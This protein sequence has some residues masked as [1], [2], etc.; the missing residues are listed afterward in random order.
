MAL[1]NTLSARGWALVA[2]IVFSLVVWV[3]VAVVAGHYKSKVE[4]AEDAGVQSSVDATGSSV[5]AEQEQAQAPIVADYHAEN[6][7]AARNLEVIKNE[8]RSL[9]SKST[10]SLDADLTRVVLVGLCRDP[11]RR[12]SPD[13][14]A[15][16]D[17]PE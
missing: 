14:A 13:C 9:D 17:N 6:A 16:I 7:Q 15:Y 12:D 11:A 3:T 2:L 4:K 8:I 5:Q 10:V 1:K